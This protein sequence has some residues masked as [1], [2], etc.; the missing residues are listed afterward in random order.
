MYQQE[1]YN[2]M[3]FFSNFNST[4]GHLV[5]ENA[6]ARVD[7]YR[8][9]FR[10]LNNTKINCLKLEDTGG[11]QS[12]CLSQKEGHGT[13]QNSSSNKNYFYIIYL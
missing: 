11:F 2:K 7:P 3:D 13:T 5:K 8:R 6:Y 4:M 1:F 10:V 12:L 9:N